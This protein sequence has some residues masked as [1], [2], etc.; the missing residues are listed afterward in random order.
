MLL[1][2]QNNMDWIVKLRI[3][4]K[5]SNSLVKLALDGQVIMVMLRLMVV[6]ILLMPLFK[7]QFQLLL[8]QTIGFN[9]KVEF[10][11]IVTNL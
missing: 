8:M 1:S 6:L 5:L 7:D 10:L 2:T 9:T 4:I 3:L 11:V